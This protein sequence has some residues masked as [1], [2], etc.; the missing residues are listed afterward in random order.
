MSK[1]YP[2][3]A[4]SG[5]LDARNTYLEMG[6][7]RAMLSLALADVLAPAA[8]TVPGPTPSPAGVDFVLVDRATCRLKA[9]RHLTKM[10]SRGVTHTRI[11]S[12]ICDVAL[13]LVDGLAPPRRVVL[14]SKHLCGGATDLALRAVQVATKPDEASRDGPHALDVRG[15][16]IATCCHH[17]C[18]WDQYV[19]KD[20]FLSLGF[21]CLDFERLRLLS[22]WAVCG[23]R[24]YGATVPAVDEGGS[25]EQEEPDHGHVDAGGWTG[26]A[27]YDV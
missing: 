25:E 10:K 3:V 18:T 16:A 14:V 2:A 4:C 7:G 1:F 23:W 27:R 6:C 20:W 15:V 17:R 5:L 22:S 8:E 11:R 19:A 21:T 26:E 12:D 9:D 13:R 24:G